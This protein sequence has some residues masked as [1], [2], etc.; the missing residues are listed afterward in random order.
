VHEI[1]VFVDKM[2][3]RRLAAAAMKGGEPHAT[4]KHLQYTMVFDA[5]GDE[6]R[7]VS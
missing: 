4:L 7:R 2:V 5:K 6:R 1:V 3:A